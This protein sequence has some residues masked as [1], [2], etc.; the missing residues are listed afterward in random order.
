MG[1]FASIEMFSW[2]HRGALT[3]PRFWRHA[4]TE[5]GTINDHGNRCWRK[6]RAR[7]VILLERRDFVVADQ[8]IG[9]V[10]MPLE[11]EAGVWLQIGNA[12]LDL[13]SRQRRQIALVLVGVDE[14]EVLLRL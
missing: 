8:A 14:V 1:Q 12:R 9:V 3:H 4:A 10:A 5:R 13:R 7:S 2:V 6:A 11:R